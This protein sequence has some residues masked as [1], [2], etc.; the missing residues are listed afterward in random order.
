MK[1]LNISAE[2]IIKYDNA[3]EYY[4]KVKSIIKTDEK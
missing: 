3:I 2:T 4:L 1:K